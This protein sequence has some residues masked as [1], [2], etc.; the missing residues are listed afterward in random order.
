MIGDLLF[1]GVHRYREVAMRNMARAFGWE[2]PRAQGVA[3]QAF[4][5]IGKTLVMVSEPTA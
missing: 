3:R 5:N 1:W 4:R 2:M